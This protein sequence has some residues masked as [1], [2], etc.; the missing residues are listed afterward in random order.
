MKRILGLI[1]LPNVSRS[2]SRVKEF[3]RVPEHGNLLCFDGKALTVDEFN[4]AAEKAMCAGAASIYGLQPMAKMVEIEVEDVL[5]TPPSDAAPIVP[6]LEP[7][8]PAP[9]IDL[10]KVTVEPSGDGFVLVNYEGDEARY[11]GQS[12]TWETD[13]SLI[14]PFVTE[15]DAIAASPGLIV[16]KTPEVEQGDATESLT[17]ASG[18]SAPQVEDGTPVVETPLES[19]PASAPTESVQPVVDPKN[20]R[21]TVMAAQAEKRAQKAARNAPSPKKVTPPAQ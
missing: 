19:L 17:V 11:M 20:I 4:K 5:E 7:A 6:P 14:M 10:P 21:Q 12:Q 3:R 16:A 13:V 9:V 15:A 2:V 8:K 1:Y 18:A